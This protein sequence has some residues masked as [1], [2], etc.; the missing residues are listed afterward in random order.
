MLTIVQRQLL[1]IAEHVPELRHL[2]TK[3]KA[4]PPW[5]SELIEMAALHF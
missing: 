4:K 2:V 5:S 1:Q 3:V